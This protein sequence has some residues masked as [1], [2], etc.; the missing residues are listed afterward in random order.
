MNLARFRVFS[1][2]CYGTLIDW[3]CG[4]LAALRP[5][6]EREGAA[7]ADDEILARFAHFEP[8]E[9]QTAPELTYPQILARV[10]A[11]MAREW[12]LRAEP[13]DAARFA[14][15][16]ADWP[17]FA[18]TGTALATLKG[19]VRLVVLSN[20]DRASF[21][22]TEARL[23]VKF[24]DVF[25]AQD[26][27]AYKPDP[28]TFEYLLARLGAKGFEPGDILHVAQSLYHDHVPAKALGLATCWVDRGRG[29]GGAVQAPEVAVTPDLRVRDLAELVALYRRAISG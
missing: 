2:D 11:A 17:P 1:F 8:I 28:R 18:D 15:S 19:R 20:V 6:L 26:I 12:Q 4:I 7:I 13:E 29:P 9:Q 3:E 14:A 23:G 25:T 16:I 27:G 5:W 24:D 22:R 21:A 10:H